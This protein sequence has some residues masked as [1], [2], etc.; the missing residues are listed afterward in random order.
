MIASNFVTAGSYV[1]AAWNY[2][3]TE[4]ATVT[5]ASTITPTAAL[6][7]L[8]GTTAINVMTPWFGMTTTVG[9]GGT[10]AFVDFVADSAT[11]FNAGTSVGSFKTAFTTI[12]GTPY[13]CMFTPSTELW[14]C[15]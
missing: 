9:A 5:A 1:K 13:H 7:H 8:T 3:I 12:A 10:G 4:N 15:K 14:Y 6:F 11:P 2:E